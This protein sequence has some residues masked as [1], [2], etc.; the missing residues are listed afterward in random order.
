MKLTKDTLKLDWVKIEELT[1]KP[2]PYKNMFW[3]VTDDGCILRSSQVKSSWQRHKNEDVLKH[4]YG[5]YDN[6]LILH[7]S[8]IFD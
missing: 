3:A 6:V 5:K 1:E 8:I 7:G 4:M 2:R